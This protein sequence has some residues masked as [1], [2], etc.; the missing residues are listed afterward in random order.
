MNKVFVDTSY[1]IA[2]YNQKDE[3]HELALDW[4]KR[5]K[6]ER[7]TC[8][9]T[10]PII[11][12]LGDGFSRLNRRETGIDLIQNIIQASNYVLHPFSQATYENA[13]KIYLKYRDKEWGLTDC[14]S[15]Q[16]MTE[17]KLTEVLT[18]DPHFK[19]YGFIIL[20]KHEK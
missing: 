3:F 5:I 12:E 17:Q 1:F 20:L 13:L 10:I 16:V 15:F 2:L 14:Y 11:F 6:S 4:A 19:Q 9:I 8:H 7:I 18:A